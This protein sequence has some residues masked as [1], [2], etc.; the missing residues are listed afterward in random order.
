MIIVKS[1]EEIELMRVDRIYQ[2]F[3]NDCFWNKRRVTTLYLDK[4]AEAFI[5]DH[6][7]VPSF[8]GL[9]GFP[10]SLCMSPNKWCMEF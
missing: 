2:N 10:N 4:L 5:R 6:G 8:L 9:Y 1:R 3:R 7:A